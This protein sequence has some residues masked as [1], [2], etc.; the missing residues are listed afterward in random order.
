MDIVVGAGLKPALPGLF[1]CTPFSAEAFNFAL[2]SVRFFAM[3]RAKAI[4]IPKSAEKFTM[5][6]EKFIMAGKSLLITSKGTVGKTLQ[7]DTIT[8]ILLIIKE[9]IHCDLFQIQKNSFLFLEE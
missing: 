4:E 2:L 9:L 7:K 6:G 3:R 1:F 8:F 5:A